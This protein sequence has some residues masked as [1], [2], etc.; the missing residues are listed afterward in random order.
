[1][2]KGHATGRTAEAL[3]LQEAGNLSN[4]NVTDALS[5]GVCGH[6]DRGLDLRDKRDQL[7]ALTR[8]PPQSGWVNQLP[9][10]AVDG[11]PPLTEIRVSLRRRD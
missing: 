10:P 7:C 1:V 5:P 2:P 9:Q 11:T 8:V 4:F 6:V 3:V